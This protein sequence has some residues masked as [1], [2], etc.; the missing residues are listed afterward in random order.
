MPV[1]S[2]GSWLPTMD[3]FITHWTG[4][5]TFLGLGGP[6]LLTGAYGVGQFQ[7][8]R[9]TVDASITNVENLDNTLNN[10]RGDRD[11]KRA[12][13][14]DRLRQ[15]NF[16][17]RGQFQST[18]YI[19]SLPKLPVFTSAPGAWR[20]I[21]DDDQNLWT[22]IN[23]NSPPITGFTPPFLL[24]GGYTVANFTTENNALDAV[25]TTVTNGE[26]NGQQ[27]RKQRDA[28]FKPPYSRMKQYRLAVRSVLPAGH[29]L[30][31]SIP[32]LTPAPG[33]TPPAANLSGVWNAG[34]QM[35]DLVWAHSN[36]AVVD[37]WEVRQHSGPVY[38][39]SE[40]QAVPGGNLPVGTMSFSTDFTLV[41][42]G[43]QALFKVYAVTPTGN[44]KGSNAVKIVRP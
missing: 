34:T 43:S 11:I 21:M 32:L 20:R 15:F 28:D 24:A 42:P 40:E 14:L 1:T 30:L 12:A 39:V 41:A 2:V 44:E 13:M 38:K 37:H 33:S 3:E 22:T 8:D 23:T 29:P 26:Q 7:L 18:K 5:N 19:L 27:A 36:V 9:I 25:F 10:A 17:V 4:V 35:A 16:G 6:F 31:L